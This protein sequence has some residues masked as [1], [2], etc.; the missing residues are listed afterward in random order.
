LV[1]LF[2]DALDTL[3]PGALTQL[4]KKHWAVVISLALPLLLTTWTNIKQI[5]EGPATLAAIQEDYEA[6]HK[7]LGQV[8]DDL[9]AI[10]KESDQAHKEIKEQIERVLWSVGPRAP[11]PASQP[12]PR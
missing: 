4:I 12:V 11:L 6:D 8:I 2:K 1:P 5:W 10:K 9:A 7:K 3:P